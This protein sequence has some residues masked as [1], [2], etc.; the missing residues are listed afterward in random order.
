MDCEGDLVIFGEHCNLQKARKVIDEDKY[1]DPKEWYEPENIWL[2]FCLFSYEGEP[3][4]GFL[5]LDDEPESMRGCIIATRL[6][7][8]KVWDVSL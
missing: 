2:R 3:T 8:V 5:E 4:N 7:N 6:K 1:D